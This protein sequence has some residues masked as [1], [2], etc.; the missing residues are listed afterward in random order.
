MAGSSDSEWV[1]A[2]VARYEQPLLRYAHRLTNDL[3]RA[4]DV[5]QDTF[6]RLCR[7]P[8]KDIE[9]RLAQWLFTVCRNR[10]LDTARKES[11]MKPAS[12]TMPDVATSDAPAP[13]AVMERDETLGRAMRFL[14][15]LPQNQQEVLRLKFGEGLSYKEISGITQLT[16]SH[17]GVLIHNGLKTLRVRM[18]ATP[19]MAPGA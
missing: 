3:E 18:G 4:R 14:S 17:V 1:R 12:P 2:A 13:D 8:R 16:V 19:R 10:A 7:Q 9:D 15:S 6:L 5:V 11:R